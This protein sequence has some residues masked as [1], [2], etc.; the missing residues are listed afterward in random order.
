M[1]Q[2]SINVLSNK[3]L[4]PGVANTGNI[5]WVSGLNG[6]KNWK[7][8]P[9]TTDILLDNVNKDIFYIK[10]CD[11]TGAIK[12]FRAF[13]YNEIQLD[14]VP[15]QDADTPAMINFVTKDDLAAFKSE[16]LEAIKGSNSNSYHKNNNRKQN[17]N[18]GS[19]NDNMG[20]NSESTNQY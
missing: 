5:N 12:T 4:N 17:Y 6:S 20:R 7:M 9:N 18:G 10:S 3:A 8:Y 19:Q 14:E 13:K 15:L 16:I 2:T 11:E 1:P